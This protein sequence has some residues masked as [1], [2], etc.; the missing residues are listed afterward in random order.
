MEEKSNISVIILAAGQGKRMNNPDLPKVLVNLGDKPMLSYVLDSVN[1][2]NPDQ[3]IIVIGHKREKV[4]DFCNRFYE[5][6]SFAI[7]EQQLGTGHAVDQAREYL[8]NFTGDVLILAGD[9]PLLKSDTLNKFIDLH[10]KSYS[11]LSVLSTI[12][13]NPKGY[14][15][16]VRNSTGLFIKITEHK[17]A[18]T[19][20]LKIHEINSGIFLVNSRILFDL[21]SKIDNKNAQG[22]YY[23]TDIV[24]L[25]V[26]SGINV[27]AFNCAEYDELQGINSPEDLEKAELALNIKLNNS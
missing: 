19:E 6:I 23:L 2:L 3:I 27:N 14:G 25:A 13:T 26:A 5:N 1:D 24:D 9:V 17:D 16:I 10:V 22:E 12:A 4:R 15:R 21:L 8:H 18:D 7:Q 20:V 11:Q